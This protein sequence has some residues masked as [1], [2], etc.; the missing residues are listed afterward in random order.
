MNTDSELPMSKLCGFG[1]ITLL[2]LP[3][4]ALAVYFTVL[5]SGMMDEW[6]TER[7]DVL[8][9]GSFA[10]LSWLS[11]GIA[12]LAGWTLLRRPSTTFHIWLI[13]SLTCAVTVIIGLLMVSLIVVEG[14]LGLILI[15]PFILFLAMAIELFSLPAMSE[16][17]Q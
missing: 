8:L 12:L 13:R 15:P 6:S 5:L 1:G 9:V 16:A 14:G 11:G 10:L 4:L 17:G 3:L 2:A 7:E